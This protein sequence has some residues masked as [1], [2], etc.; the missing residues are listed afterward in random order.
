M[1]WR[2]VPV[3]VP[4]NQ[5]RNLPGVFKMA[6]IFARSPDILA[7]MQAGKVIFHPQGFQGVGVFG[8]LNVG[9]LTV[10]QLDVDVVTDLPV[11]WGI[12]RRFVG[13]D[14]EDLNL[15]VENGGKEPVE[16][17]SGRR[18]IPGKDGLKDQVVADIGDIDI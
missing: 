2:F 8:H 10:F 14:G 16:G 17:L 12:R 1:Y 6:E 18:G 4:I 7:A 11:R 9:A 13:F 15:S 5:E 3:Q